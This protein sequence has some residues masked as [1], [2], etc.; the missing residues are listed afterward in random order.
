MRTG[1]GLN[2][3]P[4]SW[5]KIPPKR[6]ASDA[7]FRGKHCSGAFGGSSGY[8]KQKNRF[9]KGRCQLRQCADC[10]ITGGESEN[11]GDRNDRYLT[12]KGGM[13]VSGGK[14]AGV[15]GNSAVTEGDVTVDDISLKGHGTSSVWQM[16]TSAGRL[17]PERFFQRRQS[18]DIELLPDIP[19]VIGRLHT[20]PSVRCATDDGFQ[21]DRHFRRNGGFARNQTL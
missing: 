5:F 9:R 16:T 4:I 11:T 14:G 15:Q 19:P 2:A 8:S 21:P 1:F 7:V 10:G 20:Q 3:L 6:T 13:T 17:L 18:T 12:V